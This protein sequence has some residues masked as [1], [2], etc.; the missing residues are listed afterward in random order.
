MQKFFIFLCMTGLTLPATAQQQDINFTSLTTKDGLSSNSI[1][2]ILKD[3]Y[4]LMWFGTEDG[5]DKFDGT[6]FT[7]YRHIQGNAASLQ[8]NEIL[9]LYED[10]NGNLWVGTGGGSLSLYDRK[11][12]RFIHYP[13]NTNQNSIGSNVIRGIC[14]DE[15]GKIWIAHYSGVNILDPTTGRISSP[16]PLPDSS[17]PSSI[18]SGNA[19]MKDRKGSIWIGT[20]EGAFQYNP[21]NHSFRHFAH[22]AEDNASLSH[23]HVNTIAED[24][25]G[26]IWIGTSDGLSLLR[27][28]SNSFVNFKYSKDNNGTLSSN[29]INSIADDGEQ[30]WVGTGAGLDILDSKTGAIM[31]Y[32]LDHRNIH[33][34]TGQAV[35]FI[36]MDKQGTYWLGTVRGGIDKYDKNL[37]LFDLVLS[38]VFDDKGLKEPVVTSFAESSNGHVYVGT[39]GRGLSLFDRKTKSFH[40]FNIQSGR[41]GAD[42]RML[43]LALRMSSRNQLLIGT[44]QDGLFIWDP[45]SERYQ[46]L[47]QGTRQEDLNSN[48]IFC[49]TEDRK[50]NIWA[51]TNGNGINVLNSEKKVV[52]RYTP[53]PRQPNDVHLPI[54]G[55]IRDIQEDREGNMW[56]ATHGGGI[57]VYQPSSQKFTVYNT[58]NSKLPIDKVQTLLVDSRGLIWAG[59]FGGGLSLFDK[60][61]RQ[62]QTFTER[63]GLQNSTIYKIVEDRNGLIWVS[64]NKGISS[65][66]A[67][68]KKISNYNYHNGVQ[69]N[70]FMHGSG[71]RLTDGTLFFG[72]LEGF[73]YFNPDHLRKNTIIPPVLLT[74]L[75]VSN[76]SVA[77]SEEGPIKEQ[78]SVAKEVTLDYK[79]NFALSFVALNYTSPEQ[80]QYAYMLENYDRH[81]TYAGT[82]NTASYTN[83]DPGKYVF[84]VKASNN[85]GVWNTAGASIT[86]IVRPPFWRTL[87]AYIFYVLAAVGLALYLRHKGIQRLKKKFALEQGK[88]QAEQE[89]KETERVHELD[90][91]KIKFL[92][93]LSHEFRTP[94]SLILGPV[95]KLLSEEKNRP[96]FQ[97]LQLIKRNGRR[98][99]NLVNQLLDFRKMEEH[100][101]K[102]HVSDG[103]LVS[104]VREVSGSF[105]DLSEKKKIRFSFNSRIEK[106]ATSFDHD[107]LERILF[108]LLSNAFK[109]TLEGGSIKLDMDMRAHDP[110][111]PAKTWV[112]I[113]VSDTGI[114]MPEDTKEKI[115][116][117]FFQ[118]TTA[119]AVLNQ[120]SG[121]G[122]SIT[123]EFVKMQGGTIQVDSE[124]GKG[125]TFEIQLPFVVKDPSEAI[126]DQLSEEIFSNG[127]PA[128]VEEPVEIGAETDPVKTRMDMPSVLLVEDNEDFRFYLKD[129]LRLHYKVL[130]AADGKEGWQK[131]LAHH[132][133]LIV[134]DI[135]MPHMNGIELSRKIKADKRTGHIPVILLTAL[136][137]EEDQLKGLETGA[138]DYITK[139]FNFEVLNAKIRNLLALNSNLKNTYTK[140]I[141]ILT[142]EV[143]IESEDEK[144]LHTI[145][146]YLEQN[147]TNSQLSVEELS[148]HV[149][150]SRSSLYNKLLELTGQT[151]VEYIRSV[152]LDKAAVLL[153]KSDMNV[154]EIAYSVGFSTPNYFTKSFKAKFNMLPSEY[155]HK[156]RREN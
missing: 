68:T 107:K 41:K 106:L 122:L 6:N 97:Q 81:W 13:S 85:D 25:K 89:R 124:P 53:V 140:Q 76:Q 155:I 146:L 20:D 84:R 49:I 42:N 83:L 60:K 34:L 5:L 50:G 21:A 96:S 39:E 120:G 95:D 154:A 70:N 37:N 112:S 32:G 40:Y 136:T 71:L 28:G 93:N 117:R 67:R 148:R 125:T 141:K 86:V 58:A 134:S 110:E 8:A 116:D 87:Y 82:S 73:N 131:A 2:A 104:F 17:V 90:R 101:L 138:S 113:K 151:P 137:R 108:N 153:E 47:V 54:N 142:P 16:P 79:Q 145:M 114:G 65:M 126:Q 147:L 94:I 103:E 99:L 56:I 1:N 78:I 149:G 66:D 51:G 36:C 98:L 26:N 22:L 118:N 115:F 143:K 9:S 48:E 111:N 75:K 24:Q 10:R 144:L 7:V 12:D 69:Y 109:F 88:I 74:D 3:R 100:E 139:P 45:L 11:K 80:N 19:I 23:N 44:Y 33:S 135:S 64:T 119:A 62:F 77:A 52:V 29:L 92:T 57:A 150:M 43:I 102:L 129:N 30:L 105:E 152:K 38:N 4:G 35:R 15:A 61:S 130:E 27:P 55:Y 59:T 91:L 14:S 46:Q 31:R 121:I 133:Q 123:K 132:P 156:M 127:E 128:P 18:Q 72:G 63:E